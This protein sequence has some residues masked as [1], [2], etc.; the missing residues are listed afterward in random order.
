MSLF[1]RHPAEFGS[2]CKDLGEMM[3]IPQQKFLR[4]NEQGVLDLTMGGIQTEQGTGWMDQAILFC[5][6]WEARLQIKDEIR[7]KP[8]SA[9][10]HFE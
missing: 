1:S 5:L 8:G 7:Q 6:F 2:C 9:P 4:A 3:T 10:P